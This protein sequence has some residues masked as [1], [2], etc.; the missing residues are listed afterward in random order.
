M[1]QVA[2]WTSFS[3]TTGHEERLVPHDGYYPL[4]ADGKTTAMPKSLQGPITF[5][6]DPP[7]AVGCSLNNGVLTVSTNQGTVAVKASIGGV[8]SCATAT[9]LFDLKATS[10]SQCASGSCPLFGAPVTANNNNVDV[11]I[12]LGSS[13]IQGSSGYVQVQGTAPSTGLGTP[14]TLRCDFIRPELEKIVDSTGLLTQIKAQDGLVTVVTNSGSSYSLSFYGPSQVGAKAGGAYT[15][16]GSPSKITT[17]EN[18]GGDTNHF[19]VTDSVKGIIAD[20]Y[21][22]G[23]GWNLVQGGGLRQEV[24]QQTVNGNQRTVLRQ[25]Q[26]SVNVAR[27]GTVVYQTFPLGENIILQVDGTGSAARTNAYAYDDSGRLLSATHPDGGWEIYQ[28]DAQGRQVNRFSPWLNSAPTT[29]S[30]NCRLTTLDYSTNALAGS[31]DDGQ[32]LPNTARCSIDYIQGQEASRRYTVLTPGWRQDIQCVAPG[33]TWNDTNNLATTT[34]YYTSAP[35]YGQTSKIVRPNGTTEAFI[36]DK[37]S[38]SG[39]SYTRST[40]YSGATDANGAFIMGTKEEVYRDPATQRTVNRVATDIASQ[41]VTDNERYYYDSQGHLTNTVYLDGTQTTQNYDC[42]HLLSSTD[43]NGI[44]TSY[45]YDALDRV[46]TS[47]RDGIT[48]SNEFN[49][50][51]AVTKTHRIGT[52]GTD[53]VTSEAAYDTSGQQPWSTDALSRT[54][55]STNFVDATG[56]SIDITTSLGITRTSIRGRDGSPLSETSNAGRQMRYA[57]GVEQLNGINCTFTK[58]ITLDTNGT[59][60]AEW[61]KSY[62]N[63]AGQAVETLYSDNAASTMS[64]ANGQLVRSVDADGVVTLCA[65]G[66]LGQVEF[67]AIDVN[68]NGTIDLAGPDHITQTVSDVAWHGTNV[69]HRSQTFVYNQASSATPTLI[70]SSET[71]VGGRVSWSFSGSGTSQT[72]ETV[73]DNGTW[74]STTTGGNGTISQA[75]YQGDRLISTVIAD[76]AGTIQQSTREYD[77]FN[78]LVKINDARNGA[79]TY[80]YNNADQVVA[81]TNPPPSTGAAASSTASVYDDYGR[82]VLEQK[83]D[84]TWKTNQFYLDRNLQMESGSGTYQIQYTYDYAGRKQTMT[85][86]GAAGAATTTWSYND[87]GL[88]ANKRYA[89]NNGPSYTYTP[90]GRLATRTWARPVTTTYAYDTG[91]NL[92]SITYS[93]GT[94]GVSF[95]YDR[96]GRL[97]S[98]NG[99]TTNN[100]TYSAFGQLLAEDA[101]NVALNYYNQL[102]LGYDSVGRLTTISNALLN[103]ATSFGWAGNRLASVSDGTRQTSY[104][105]VPNS[106][107]LASTAIQQS[108]NPVVTVSRQYDYLNRLLSISTDQ[109]LSAAYA[110][111]AANQRTAL[112]NGD[113]SAW[114]Y[115]YDFLGQVTN[116]TKRWASGQLAAGQQ[117][118]YFFDAIGNRT[119]T[120]LGGNSDGTGIRTAQYSV[121]SLNQ[122]TSRQVP[123]FIEA[124]GTAALTATVTVNGLSPIW[125]GSYFRQEVAAQN[126]ASSV[127]TNIVIIAAD[128]TNTA[129]VVRTTVV[130]KTPEVFQYDL[131]GNLTQDGQWN[132]TWDAESRLIHMES[133]AGTVPDNFRLQL[134]FASDWQGRRI[135]KTV[136]LW[137]PNSGAYEM[138]SRTLFYYEGWNIIAEQEQITRRLTTYVWGQDLSGSRQGAGGV[139]GLLWLT[140]DAGPNAG[141]YAPAYDGNGNVIGLVNTANG[142]VAAQYEYG[143]FGE[144]VKV[145]GPVARECHVLFSTKYNDFETG[146]Y[147]YGKRPYSPITARWLTVDHIEEQGGLNLYSFVNNRPTTDID[148]LGMADWR[149]VPHL[150]ALYDSVVRPYLANSARALPYLIR[151]DRNTNVHIVYIPAS[152]NGYSQ[153]TERLNWLYQEWMMN[154][155]EPHETGSPAIGLMHEIIHVVQYA[156]GPDAAKA[157]EEET[158]Q[159][160][161][162]DNDLLEA[163]TMEEERRIADE[164]NKK[165]HLQEPEWLRPDHTIGILFNAPNSIQT[166]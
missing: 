115:G 160:N 72:I 145:I 137:N 161:P 118:A 130:P 33:A 13:A 93:D 148:L 106:T 131:D 18:V 100:L 110:Y 50:N 77:V 108:G 34:W 136:S 119:Y 82:A 153:V 109:G 133:L 164:I 36:Y 152:P 70:S 28:Y 68:Q 20:Y 102:R 134:D 27:E 88:L 75:S 30:A 14:A 158:R 71:A 139:G 44:V 96:M 32:T 97:S 21:W 24:Q 1:A 55:T 9:F 123:G 141:S 46:A 149:A 89:D 104:G 42:C 76:A 16:T 57:Y 47:L 87:R 154:P 91:G 66:A 63:A 67:Q 6:L 165:L 101:S 41:M 83:P 22:Q 147:N 113:G 43:R 146:H 79:T 17:L 117:F 120:G 122:Y 31:G 94:P 163:I 35:Y 114:S 74:T 166:R 124:S 156:V 26:D 103:Y 62:Q 80:A 90:G 69:V 60:T 159:A 25:V 85:T 56:Q 53:V 5:A 11:Q 2:D 8:G 99:V 129:A 98:V 29:N 128:V 10:C 86:Q 81:V 112:T 15:V 58:V 7:N 51:G 39:I 144:I 38:I 150:R 121:N 132:Y 127:F 3:S 59:D 4:Q 151:F 73:G 64:Y 140:E 135:A 126:A 12:E 19:R 54:T 52:D 105:Y 37:A 155:G 138:Q 48:T 111:N 162:M 61:T 84:G 23:S 40:H 49:A 143:P 92:S 107:L 65:Y 78:R 116:G 157:C 125:Q 142:S 45:G 95:G